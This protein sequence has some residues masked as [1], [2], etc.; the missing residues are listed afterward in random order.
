MGISSHPRTQTNL[1][2]KPPTI[3]FRRDRLS[4]GDRSDLDAYA[5]LLRS[6]YGTPEGRPVFPRRRP[7]AEQEPDSPRTRPQKPR[8]TGLNR[9]DHPWRG[10]L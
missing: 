10:T 8:A 9:A 5:E 3:Y 4:S 6:Y 1:Q 2:H 7:T